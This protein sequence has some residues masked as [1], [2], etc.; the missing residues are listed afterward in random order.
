MAEESSTVSHLSVAMTTNE[1]DN[2]QT[3][4]ADSMTSSFIFGTD[5]Y[6][7]FTVILM[8]AVGTVGN[9]LVLY[10]MYVSK[11]HRKQ[12]LIFN[13]NAL[14]LLSSFNLIISYAVQICNFHLTGA[15]GYWLCIV[16]ISENLVWWGTNGSMVNLAII[17]LDRYLK[18]VYPNMSKKYLRR[19]VIYSAGA[20]AWFVGIVYNTVL[21]YYSTLVIDGLCHSFSIFE[22]H[23]AKMASVIFYVLFFYFIILTI[24][25]FCY[26]R[27][28][29]AIRRQAKVMASH[30]AAGTSNPNQA[31]SH[32]NQSN[33]IKTMILVSAFYAVAWAPHNFYYLLVSSALFPGLSFAD[34]GYYSTMFIAFIYTCTNP[35]IYAIKFDPVKK[36]LIKMIPCKKNT[37]QPSDNT[38]STGTSTGNKRTRPGASVVT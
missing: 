21:V 4:S 33:V 3:M 16:F 30:S 15:L 22:S 18:V 17:T 35:F 36:V 23:A 13:Q 9:G 7:K 27:I 19:W 2:T 38:M 20:F 6:L 34:N 8:G 28:L 37:V 26:W 25:I 11:Q 29:V 31:Q 10:A 24:F 1:I 12:V 32:K 14:D 5:F